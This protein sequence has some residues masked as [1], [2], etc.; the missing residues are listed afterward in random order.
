VPREFDQRLRLDYALQNHP[1]L[2]D[3]LM[4]EPASVLEELGADEA[5]LECPDK[6]HAAYERSAT[7]A[8]KANELGN[9]SLVEALPKLH[10]VI[11]DGLGPEFDTFKVPFGV[12]FA[13]RVEG[14]VG[15]DVTGTGSVECTFGLEC[16]PDVD[17]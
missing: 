2:M 10:D 12:R 13:E 14:V 15:M 4:K 7:V 11:R 17:G 6:A 9:A 3:R 16:K 5:A 1:A 8:D